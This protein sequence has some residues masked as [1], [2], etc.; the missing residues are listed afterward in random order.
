MRTSTLFITAI[1]LLFIHEKQ[2]Q[3]YLFNTSDTT[4]NSTDLLNT[5]TNTRY[6]CHYSRLWCGCYSKTGG[7][8]VG[9]SPSTFII[10]YNQ[11]ACFP[12]KNHFLSGFTS[13]F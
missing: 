5:N 4:T 12:L 1:L 9:C 10:L 8:Q 7:C 11:T 3:I 13:T 2:F 6:T